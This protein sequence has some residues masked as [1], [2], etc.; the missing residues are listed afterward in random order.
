MVV[1]GCATASAV[2]DPPGAPQGAANPVLDVPARG[3][4]PA[5]EEVQAVRAASGVTA[6]R[7]E[8]TLAVQRRA[9]KVNIVEQLEQ[10][11]GPEYA[12]VWFDT[13]AGEF[14]VPTSTAGETAAAKKA[15]AQKV[16]Q[17]FLAAS[18]GESFRTEQV[19]FSE[20]EL[21]AA[22]LDLGERLSDYFEARLAQ[23]ALDPGANA[24]I[25][26]VPESIDVEALAEIEE[27]ASASTVTVEVRRLPDEAFEAQPAACNEA[28]RKCDLPVRSGQ[29]IYGG[30]F[31][32]PEGANY[33]E[34][35]SVGFRANGSDGKKYILTAGHCVLQNAKVG[36]TPIWSWIT[37]SPNEGTNSIGTTTQ[38]HYDGK[39]WAKIDATGTWADTAPWPTM[40]AYWGATHE[41]PIVGEAKSYKGQ[42]LCHIG[43]N[44]GSSCGIVKEVNVTVEYGES[45]KLNSMFE[46][47]GSG[48]ALAGGD[49]G[50]PV[51][52]S[53]IALGI[54]SGGYQ[55]YSN[56]TLYF[57]DIMAANAE[58]NVNIT[59]PGAPEA[60]TGA[61]INVQP[62]QATVGGQVN[63]HGLQTSYRF[64][65]GQG[66]YTHGVEGNAGAGQG[67]VSQSAVLAGLEPL[68]TYKYRLR[69]T[70]SLN[71]AYGK[72]G[73]FSTPGA[74]PKVWSAPVSSSGLTSATLAGSISPEGSATTYHFEYG[75]TTS[76]GTRV[77]LSDEAVGNGRAAVNVSQ[78]VTGLNP[79]TIYHYRVVATNA[80]GV[81]KGPDRT[82]STLPR[83]PAYLSS[84]NGTGPGATQPLRPTWLAVDAAGNVY[85][86]D[87]LNS[88]VVKY[89]A[90]GEYLSH[91]GSAGSGDGQFK[92]PRGIAISPVNGNV[93]V[94]D[95]GNARI[96][97]FTPSGT[98]VSK[99]TANLLA[100]Y[101]L[102]IDGEGVI[103]ASDPGKLVQFVPLTTGGYSSSTETTVNGQPMNRPGGLGIDAD[104]DVWVAETG[105]DRVVEWERNFNNGK[106]RYDAF[107]RFGS[108]GTGP[109]QFAE[110][111][112]VAVKPSGNLFVL[113]RNNS[114]VQQMS[115]TG[116][117]LGSFGTAGS[118]SG[119]LKEPVG[120]A[121]GQ[122]G[123]LYVTDLGNYRVQR[124]SQPMRP[125]AITQSAGAI[126]EN[127]ATINGVVN[128]DGLP[129]T[130]RFEY[131]KTT[132]YGSSSPL[133][134]E[135]VG[136]GIVRIAKS[137][138]LTGLT[139]CT[140]YHY[141]IVATNSD[142][143]TH[144]RDATFDT[145]CVFLSSF[146]GT[147]PGATQ[148]LRPIWPAV[149]GAGNVYVADRL[150]NRV[151]KYS[152]GGEYLSHFG[153][154]GSANGQ[155]NE[156][157]GVAVSPVT[158]NIF[159]AEV[160]NA[161]IQEFT[162]SGVFVS[163]LTQNLLTPY[164]LVID[165]NGLITVSDAGKLVQFKPLA[166]GG[167]ESVVESTVN[168]QAMNRPG[169]LGLDPEGDVWVAETGTNRAVEWV[170]NFG[171]TGKPAYQANVRFGATGS[172]PGQFNEAYDVAV[173]SSGNLFVLDFKNNR[174]QQMSPTGE[175]LGSFGA[176]GS[177]SGQFKEP[178]GLVLGQGGVLYVTDMGN[179]RVQRWKVE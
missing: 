110:V 116:E 2:A 104:G 14:V 91:F 127:S 143:S 139:P 171:P 67:F 151:V 97:E 26:R 102:V 141:R 10:R 3:G 87:R 7:A 73:T 4:T 106:P 59:G 44:T 125:E 43:M 162:P 60:F 132:A 144:G 68:R 47:V 152:P 15:V 32:G 158:G 126:T 95:N 17:E 78:S 115:P 154:A 174:V 128:P 80:Y 11:L 8:A 48:L 65:Y 137:R 156:P 167:Y 148:P 93:F 107:V 100:P 94:A 160:G 70:N 123:V 140:R 84:F 1:I 117:F 12:G 20:A 119:Q 121:L 163:K 76:Y 63:P 118:G 90:A 54:V 13:I 77:P 27:I 52:A 159:V 122:G 64:E 31:P 42:T 173:K 38:W 89:N 112:D 41:Y 37:Q 19:P 170:R 72:E 155:F 79:D 23:T 168:G 39:D 58:L 101:D 82:F 74:P 34:I 33:Y 172:G 103:T 40:G 55:A 85:V 62:Y 178:V 147:G 131:G 22:Q 169:G 135:S 149:D 146:S 105:T 49:S 5:A 136:S 96:Q 166:G 114:R 150:N 157:R 69:A 165:E 75:P 9:T 25:V 142:G 18:L 57:S 176:S 61:P 138:S 21:E 113:D 129:T 124:W 175:F 66:A 161:R 45:A 153:S 56:A 111:Y 6:T 30:P 88:R 99:L 71:T 120:L 53:N 109:G 179:N 177:G 92:E 98:F 134:P 50:G 83:E 86:S 133:S 145:E 29:V 35:C 51:V 81:T 16:A 130:Y 108:S 36:G 24:V 46:V 164:D 28:E